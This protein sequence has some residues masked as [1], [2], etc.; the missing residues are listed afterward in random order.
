MGQRR[1]ACGCLRALTPGARRVLRQA[2]GEARH[3][4]SGRI[5]PEHVLLAL[6]R[7]QEASGRQLMELS[8]IC[9][10]GYLPKPLTG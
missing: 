10:D 3:T 2:A 8:G 1:R 7:Q 5:R 4:G 9:V 6:A